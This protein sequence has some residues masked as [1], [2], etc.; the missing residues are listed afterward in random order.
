MRDLLVQ[1]LRGPGTVIHLGPEDHVEFQ[2]E[3]ASNR[4]GR[5][6]GIELALPLG[7]SLFISSLESGSVQLA[8]SGF[9]QGAVPRV[10]Q[11]PVNITVTLVPPS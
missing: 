5:P 1:R 4:D 11:V 2:F 3:G 6:L 9:F 7:S 8:L 10:A